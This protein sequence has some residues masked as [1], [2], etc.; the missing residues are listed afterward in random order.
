MADA[1]KVDFLKSRIKELEL[2]LMSIRA[3]AKFEQ[4]QPTGLHM[5][6]LSLIEKEANLALAGCDTY[7]AELDLE[8]ED[9]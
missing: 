5:T 6:C 1:K 3:K 9:G 2:A 8:G 4:D 7:D